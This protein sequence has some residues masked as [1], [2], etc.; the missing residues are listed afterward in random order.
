MSEPAPVGELHAAAGE[1][2]V[3]VPFQAAG[4]PP[5]SFGGEVANR[6]DTLMVRLE[7]DNGIVG[8]G[9]AFSR[10]QDRSLQSAIDTRAV[11]ACSDACFPMK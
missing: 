5:W 4:T 2:R 7:T 1:Y 8:W 9:E 3:L 6:F 10:N 11:I